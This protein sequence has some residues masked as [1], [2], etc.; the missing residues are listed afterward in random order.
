MHFSKEFYKIAEEQIKP[1]R[2]IAT[3]IPSTTGFAEFN[4]KIKDLASKYRI[5]FLLETSKTIPSL[6]I[7]GTAYDREW[8]ICDS[9]EPSRY[10]D[11]EYTVRRRHNFP[12]TVKYSGDLAISKANPR[13]VSLRGE[14]E[15]TFKSVDVTRA[16]A[17]DAFDFFSFGD[18]YTKNFSQIY[19]EAYH[20]IFGKPKAPSITLDGQFMRLSLD[21]DSLLG[22]WVNIN[23]HGILLNKGQRFDLVITE[24]EWQAYQKVNPISVTPVV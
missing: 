11:V 15:Y 5:P 14:P 4:R 10:R 13:Q 23:N 16:T 22:Q 9:Y 12:L 3:V 7:L 19:Q 1:Y 6:D 24:D 20:A 17:K 2:T 8:E 21:L 18:D